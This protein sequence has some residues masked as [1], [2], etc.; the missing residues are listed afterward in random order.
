MIYKATV[1][2]IETISNFS[3]LHIIT[4]VMLLGIIFVLSYI[5][6][7]KLVYLNCRKNNEND[8]TIICNSN[9]MRNKIRRLLND[10]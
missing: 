2:L 1:D 8:L 6:L 4:I 7:K 9:S 10:N 3:G 5:G